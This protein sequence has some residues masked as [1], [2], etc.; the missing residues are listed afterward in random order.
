MRCLPYTISRRSLGRT[1]VTWWC[2][3]IAVVVT[4]GYCTFVGYS[5]ILFILQTFS[6]PTHTRYS[7]IQLN[8]SMLCTYFALF[9]LLQWGSIWTES[10]TG[11][12]HRLPSLVRNWLPTSTMSS[13]AKTKLKTARDAL[14]KKQYEPAR[15]AAL[16]VLDYEPDNYNACAP[17]QTLSCT[18]DSTDRTI[19][20]YSLVSPSSS[21]E[22]TIRARK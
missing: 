9:Q 14:G 13:F 18:I 4:R 8:N 22:S 19:V 10:V 17:A 5:C 16:Q 11:S 7:Y 2:S 6:G 20:M 15:D 12:P 3:R 1:K 21:W